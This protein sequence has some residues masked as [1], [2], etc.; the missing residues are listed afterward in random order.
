MNRIIKTV[1]LCA[2]FAL[3]P[4]AFVNAQTGSMSKS[5]MSEKSAVTP[6]D[7]D[8]MTHAAAGGMA[9]VALGQLGNEKATSDAVKQF[10]GHM[11][12]D[13]TKANDELKAL[14][15]KKSVDLPA[16]PTPAQKADAAKLQAMSGNAFDD[17][18]MKQMVADHKKTIALFEK[19]ASSGSDADTKAFASKTLPTLKSHL[20]MAE[21]VLAKK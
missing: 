4:T 20:K 16:E 21:E 3:A 1:T 15:A 9:E 19:E 8:F 7:R 2:A 13:H 14:A 18:F 10:G 12:T 6:A 17:A 5:D 11:V